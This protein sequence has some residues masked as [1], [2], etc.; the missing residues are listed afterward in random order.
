M[1]WFCFVINSAAPSARRDGRNRGLH[2]VEGLGEGIAQFGH[3]RQVPGSQ[4]AHTHHVHIV[5]DGLSRHLARRRE[6]RA[7]VDVEA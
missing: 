3:E 7:D 4:R 5:L 6:Q 2:H 1:V